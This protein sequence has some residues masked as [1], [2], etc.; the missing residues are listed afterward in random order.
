MKITALR[1]VL[2]E[3]P[4]DPPIGIGRGELRSNGCV[5]VFLD[6]DQ[7][8]TGEGLI[9]SLNAQRLRL[10]NDMVRSFEPLLVGLDPMLSGSFTLRAG[11][12]ARNFGSSGISILGLAGVEMALWDLR[13][14]LLELNVSR[15][16]GACHTM[17]P[18][19][20]SGELW[21]SLSIDKLQRSAAQHVARG[22][23][24]MKMRLTGVAREDVARVR[25]VR[26]AIGAGIALMADLNQKLTV[27]SAIRLGRMLEEFDLAWLEEPIA[28][29]DH[30]GEAEVAAA[31]DTPIAS[32]ESVYASRAVF[33]MLQCRSVDVLMPDLQRMGGPSEFLKAATLAEAH[34]IPVSGHLFPEMSLA[35]LAAIPN[36]SVLEYMPWASPLYAQQIELDANGSAIVPQRPGWGFSFDPDA[37]RRFSLKE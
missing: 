1:T 6:T 21:V 35:L 30:K 23:R 34:G 32:G 17:L 14:R 37:V 24:A 27:P 4:F 11:A 5:L 33:E 10:L 19:Y 18:V 3:I 26:E 25:A 31:L 2:A 29:H 9:C 12:D 28:A 7:G 20:H 36:A 8:V 16:L 13:G 22:Y 15:M